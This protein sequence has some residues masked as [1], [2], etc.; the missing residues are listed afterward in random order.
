MVN[1]RYWLRLFFSV[2]LG[3]AI[4]AIAF[5]CSRY[6]LAAPQGWPKALAS[7]VEVLVLVGISIPIA[8]SV[9]RGPEW[10]PVLRHLIV[11]SVGTGSVLAAIG[12]FVVEIEV[13]TAGKLF[14]TSAY[15]T[16]VAIV[17]W[18][19]GFWVWVVVR[20]RMAS[21]RQNERSRSSG[22]ASGT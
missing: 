17:V 5:M 6:E 11:W 3:F 18:F 19:A 16:A 22:G 2:S 12:I 10:G 1:R 13:D 14:W 15:V 8:L 9:A 4:M 21:R 7:L 20:L